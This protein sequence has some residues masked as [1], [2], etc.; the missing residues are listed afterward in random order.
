MK[1]TKAIYRPFPQSV[2]AAYLIDHP[3]AAPCKAIW[4]WWLPGS[5]MRPTL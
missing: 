1:P 2:P 3:R 5:S 4:R